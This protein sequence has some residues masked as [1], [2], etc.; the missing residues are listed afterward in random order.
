MRVAQLLNYSK[1]KLDLSLNEIAKPVAGPGEVLVK[2]AYAGVNPLDNMITRGEVK[3]ILPYKLPLVAGNEFSGFVEE[4]GQGVTDFEIGQ[5]VYARLPLDKTGA[6]GEWLAIDAKAL[7]PVPDYLSLEEAAAVPLT[8]LTAFQALDKMQVE[9]GK[10]LFIS[11]GSGGFGAMAIPLAK[12]RGLEVYTN[13]SG[14][15]EA[16]VRALGADHYINYQ[17]EDFSQVL[18]DMDYVIDTLGGQ[19][20]EKQFAILKEGGQLVS[21]KGMPNK[22]FAKEMSFSAIK[23]FLMGL[24]GAKYDRLAKKKGQVYQFLF[25]QANGQQLR[26]ISQLL[27]EKQIAVSI[28]Q[29]FAFDEVNKALKKVDQG[30]SQGKTIL[31]IEA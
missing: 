8:A 30:S 21:L 25:V 24:V 20:L 6:F 4:R 27:Q 28:D 12:A 23:Q 7:A 2:I 9:A 11:G 14:R 22:A 29:V 17:E 16:R 13:G 1:E 3:L 31:K 19:E 15:N 18:S 10:K 26:Q 5:R